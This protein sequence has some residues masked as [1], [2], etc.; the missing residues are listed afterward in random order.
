[1]KKH[2][3]YTTMYSIF[4]TGEFEKS[5]FIHTQVIMKKATV[6]IDGH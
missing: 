3:H 5:P 2:I 4:T 1:M 6:L